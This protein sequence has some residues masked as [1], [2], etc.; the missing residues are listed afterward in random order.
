MYGR[1]PKKDRNRDYTKFLRKPEAK[2][3]FIR[4]HKKPIGMD[5]PIIIRRDSH[6][7]NVVNISE[8]IKETHQEILDKR[9]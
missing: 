2:T 9:K 8:K 4:I 6:Q 5:K 1:Q 7:E 3:C